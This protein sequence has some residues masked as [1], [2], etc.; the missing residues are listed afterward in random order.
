MF[1]VVKALV[2]MAIGS[3]DSV[4]GFSH[5]QFSFAV[6]QAVDLC[7]CISFYRLQ[8]AGQFGVAGEVQQQVDMVGHDDVSY[9]VIVD[10]IVM[11]EGA[12][13]DA[14]HGVMPEQAAPMAVVE[15]LLCHGSDP[16]PIF[17]LD[18]HIPRPGMVT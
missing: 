16:V 13:D 7:C 1:Y 5:P 12:G 11:V 18:C 17:F 6:H 9:K 8:D 14:A 15:Q 2:E 4:E 3:Y 10:S